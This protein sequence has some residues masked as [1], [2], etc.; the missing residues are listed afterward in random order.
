VIRDVAV[1]V[2]VVA[3]VVV[4]GL[5][6]AG[7][8]SAADPTSISSERTVPPSQAAAAIFDW[9]AGLLYDLQ[10]FSRDRDDWHT[11]RLAVRKKVSPGIVGLE[12]LRTHRF[13]EVDEAVALDVIFR[14][15]RSAYGNLRFQAAIDSEVLPPT[16]GMVE[17]FQG[18]PAGWELSGAYR[19][20]DVPESMVHVVTAGIAKYIGDDWYL[21]QRTTFSIAEGDTNVLFGASARRFLRVPDDWIQLEGAI[22]RETVD[23]AR[24]PI[25]LSRRVEF[26][27]LRFQKFFVP[28]VGVAVAGTYRDEHDGPASVGVSIELL[29]RW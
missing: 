21:R 20:L 26:V 4:V 5:F 7:S 6:P 10:S 9:E 25:V 22:G 19:N 2:L 14:L 1:T 29:T 13:G 11:Y 8:A 18:L 3:V 17:I 16:D 27:G 24:G 28:R 23:V 12:V 15:W